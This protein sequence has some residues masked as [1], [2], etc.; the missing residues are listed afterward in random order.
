MSDD[1]RARWT[2]CAM[3]RAR[4]PTGY[5]SEHA[6]GTPRHLAEPQTRSKEAA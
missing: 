4:R 6:E 3:R 1:R 5:C 2:S